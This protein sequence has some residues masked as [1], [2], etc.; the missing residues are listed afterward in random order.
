MT[1]KARLPFSGRWVHHCDECR[2]LAQDRR[3]DYY[4]C[5]GSHGP[6]PGVW[7]IARFSHDP[8]D[9]TACRNECAYN[10][11]L[12]KCQRLARFM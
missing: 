6:E 10:E 7:L 8:L 3:F 4:I 1:H 5:Y 11:E 2:L 12:E 9:Y